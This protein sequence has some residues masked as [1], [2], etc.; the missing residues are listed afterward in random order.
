MAQWKTDGD[1]VYFITEPQ[2]DYVNVDKPI[3]YKLGRISF[4]GKTIE[5]VNS[6][7]ASSYTIDNGWIYYF[8]NGYVGNENDFSIES[9][10][11]GL[12]KIKID[13]VKSRSCKA[14]W[15]SRA[16]MNISIMTF[17]KIYVVME[18]ICIL[19]IILNRQAE[20]YVG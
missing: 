4:D 6:I 7:T 18:I 17:T 11:V 13:A 9:E 15:N 12:Y 1:Y 3:Y 5:S 20:R 16:D 10:N 14:I 2:K 19:L 8:D